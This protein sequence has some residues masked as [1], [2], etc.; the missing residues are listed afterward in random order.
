MQL[1]LIQSKIISSKTL[2]LCGM[3]SLI[4]ASSIA[5]FASNNHIEIILCPRAD[6]YV[7]GP[8][9]GLGSIAM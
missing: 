9:Y 1:V 8:F 2:L 7:S 6:F 5:I 4:F 3:S